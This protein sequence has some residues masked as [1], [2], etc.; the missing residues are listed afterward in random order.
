METALPSNYKILPIDRYD[1]STDLNKHRYLSYPSQSLHNRRCYFF[2]H[3][4]DISH[5]SYTKL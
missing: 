2:Q 5:R 3:L 4:H 1:W